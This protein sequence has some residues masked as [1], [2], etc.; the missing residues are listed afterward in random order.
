V[1]SKRFETKASPIGNQAIN[2]RIETAAAQGPQLR[3]EITAEDR[4]RWTPAEIGPE[5]VTAWANESFDIAT[6]PSVGYSVQ[7]DGACWYSADQREYHGG[8]K[9]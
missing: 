8:D 9:L 6:S 1:I 4:A 7:K 3:S 5:K 2:A